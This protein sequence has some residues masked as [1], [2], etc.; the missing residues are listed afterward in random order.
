MA[1][2]R[3][4]LSLLYIWEWAKEKLTKEEINNKQLLATDQM[5]RTAWYVAAEQ[6]KEDILLLIWKLAKENL[7][8]EEINHKFERYRT[9]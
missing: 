7:T 3:G 5:G 6:S 8:T 9:N 4:K 1:A 2:E